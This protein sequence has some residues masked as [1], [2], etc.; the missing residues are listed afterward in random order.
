MPRLRSLRKDIELL[1]TV[2]HTVGIER[3]RAAGQ[4]ILREI[5]ERHRRVSWEYIKQRRDLRKRFV[6][7]TAKLL[8]CNEVESIW[9]MGISLTD[10]EDDQLKRMTKEIA[11]VDYAFWRSLGELEHRRTL[12]HKLVYSPCSPSRPSDQVSASL[13]LLVTG[14]ATCVERFPLWEIAMHV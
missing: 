11:P 7:L 10:E 4:T 8:Q 6:G 3:F 9:Q 5:Q 1:F 14:G 2:H 12:S 13:S